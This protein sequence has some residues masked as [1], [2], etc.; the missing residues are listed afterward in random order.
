MPGN[1]TFRSIDESDT[2]FLKQLYGDS[3]A[4]EFSIIPWSKQDRE[5]FIE[6]QFEAQDKSYKVNF[7]NADYR[8]I[9]LNKT[10]IGR[11]IIN[12]TDELIH[13][14][15]LAILIPFQG[16]GIGGEILSSI[17]TEAQALSVPVTLNVEQLNPAIN[18]YRRLGF[19]Q[20]GAA[21][22]HISMEWTPFR[23]PEK[24]KTPSVKK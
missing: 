24:I 11:V 23:E 21:G 9:Q 4:R 5:D 3:R 17:L 10:E 18:L 19:H 15:D 7:F 16:R 8:I 20:T 13:L 12:R 14:I 1:I 22:P 6:R 2:P